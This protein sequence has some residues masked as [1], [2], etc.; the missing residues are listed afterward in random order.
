MKEQAVRFRLGL[1]VLCTLILP[2]VLIVLFG[3]R[4]TLFRVTDKYTITFNNA[5][6]VVPGTPVRRSGVKIGEVESVELDN[7][8]GQV[9]VGVRIERKYNIRKNDDS[10]LHQNLLGGDTAIDI[11]PRPAEEGQV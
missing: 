5:P 3:G 1:F 8:T 9:I 7:D 6:G 4:P 11:V 10:V 2:A